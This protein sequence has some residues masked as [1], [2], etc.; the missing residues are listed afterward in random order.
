MKVRA[1]ASHKED[2]ASTERGEWRGNAFE[3]EHMARALIRENI[4]FVR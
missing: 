4:P 3:K 2:G 1:R